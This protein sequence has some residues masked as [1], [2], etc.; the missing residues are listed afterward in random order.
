MVIYRVL[1]SPTVHHSQYFLSTLPIQHFRVSQASKVLGVEYGHKLKVEIAVDIFQ[2]E[3]IGFHTDPFSVSKL[4]QESQKT[5]AIPL[6]S[7][8]SLT[9]CSISPGPDWNGQGGET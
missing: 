6:P 9:S 8:S 7:K 4:D 5:N 3:H 2:M 1:S